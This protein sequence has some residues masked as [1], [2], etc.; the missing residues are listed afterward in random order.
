MR[1]AAGSSLQQ[2]TAYDPLLKDVEVRTLAGNMVTVTILNVF[3]LLAGIYKAGGA[4]ANLLRPCIAMA[5]GPL[6]AIFYTDEVTPGN[7]LA[8]NPS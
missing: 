3:S 8:I 1:Q 4:F 2:C 5:R 6:R 7:V